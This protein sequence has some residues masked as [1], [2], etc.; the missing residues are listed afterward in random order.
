[1]QLAFSESHSILTA[2]EHHE[3]FREQRSRQAH[4]GSA[5]QKTNKTGSVCVWALEGKVAVNKQNF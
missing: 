3:S 2:I 4:R 1:M 5:R